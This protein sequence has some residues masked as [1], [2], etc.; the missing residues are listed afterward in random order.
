MLSEGGKR[1][2]PRPPFVFWKKIKMHR[3]IILSLAV[4]M[5]SVY[6]GRAEQV[7][8]QT[9]ENSGDAISKAF[10]NA[11][12]TG[13]DKVSVVGP[14]KGPKEKPTGEIIAGLKDDDILLDI[15]G[16]FRLKWGLLRK[17]VEILCKDIDR[18]DMQAEGNA[19]AKKIAF[20]SMCRKLL[21][22]YAEHGVFALEARHLGLTVDEEEFRTYR[23]KARE[24]YA[25][26]G[27]IGKEL[28]QLMESGESFYEHNLTNALYWKAYK[29][30]EI[31]PKI[32]LPDEDVHR[33]IAMRHE[34]NLRILAT[35][36]LKRTLI[37]DVFA[38]VRAGMD[39]GEAAERWS[40]DDSAD[41]KGVMMDEDG[42][43]VLKFTR[44]DLD[45]KL[46]AWCWRIKEGEMSDVIETPYAW[47]VVKLLKRNPATD[48]EEE[49][50][51]FAQIKLE[52]EFIEPE[53]S[54][55]EAREKA[56]ALI[57]RAAMKSKFAELLKRTKIDSKI[58][59]G[60][61]G[62]RIKI[63]RVK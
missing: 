18:P 26:K 10:Q 45:E 38:K 35:N 28:I 8:P 4:F 48:D 52:K 30:K 54:E 44:D 16:E 15:G 23:Q 62:D 53:F 11:K 51:E 21:K 31:E 20:E 34:M 37:K 29:V 9:K 13:T 57:L 27:E 25:R 61:K 5:A 14:A 49:T 40:D 63:Q 46:A 60:D 39:F 24:A 17:H 3:T 59:L 55:Q 42:E 6:G 2:K 41:T 22:D 19:A 56:R 50:V 33:F 1:M 7:A 43:S 12:T 47:H 36:D 32:E 58:P